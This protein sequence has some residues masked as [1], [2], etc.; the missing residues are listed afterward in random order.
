[1]GQV[2]A[3]T[4]DGRGGLWTLL[5]GTQSVVRLNPAD[6]SL[7]TFPVGMYPHSIELD[8]QGRL[9]FNDYLAASER[10]GS[11]DPASGALALYQ[12]GGP[13]WTAFEQRVLEPLRGRQ[14]KD[15]CERGSWIGGGRIDNPILATTFAGILVNVFR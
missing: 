14:L 13:T 5:G 15:G 8:S 6:G 2:R 10:I 12:V 9:W 4:F 7:E 11:I 1:M 3:L